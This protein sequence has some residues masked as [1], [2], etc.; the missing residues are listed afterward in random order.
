MM[1][2]TRDEKEP[3]KKGWVFVEVLGKICQCTYRKRCFTVH[4]P[5]WH[6]WTHSLNERQKV[7]NLRLPAGVHV[8]VRRQPMEVIDVATWMSVHGD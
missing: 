1:I 8:P 5:R 2:M 7:Y 4:A 3:V 6:W